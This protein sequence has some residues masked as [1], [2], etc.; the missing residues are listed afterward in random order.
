MPVSVQYNC[1]PW[2]FFLKGFKGTACKTL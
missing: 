2:C 1:V